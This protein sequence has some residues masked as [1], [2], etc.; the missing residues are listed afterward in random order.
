MKHFCKPILM[1]TVA[2]FIATGAYAEGNKNN[3]RMNTNT[4]SYNNSDGDQSRIKNQQN[5]RLSSADVKDV[6]ESL[7]DE[8]HNLAVD[9]VWGQRTVDALRAFQQQNNLNA[10]GN[11]D[12]Q[13]VAELGID[14]DGEEDMW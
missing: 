9:G 13:T 7:N 3:T 2:M 4:Q 12:S 1:A 5:N 10:T 14:I 6:Q 11:L 8:G